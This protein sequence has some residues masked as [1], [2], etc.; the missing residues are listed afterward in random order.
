MSSNFLLLKL[1]ICYLSDNMKTDGLYKNSYERMK[2][3]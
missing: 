2:I 3:H 1:L